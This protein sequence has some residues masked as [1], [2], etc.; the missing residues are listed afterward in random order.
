MPS[1]RPTTTAQEAQ[2]PFFVGVDLGGTNI[3]VG[4]VDN[5]GRTL[6]HGSVPT[7]VDSGAVD[8]SQRMG[9][10]VRQ[11]IQQAGVKQAEVA[12][13]GL[14]YAPGRWMSPRGYCWEPGESS[15]RGGS[16]RSAIG[17]RFMPAC[18]FATPMMPRRPHLAKLGSERAADSR[19]WY[20]LRSAPESAADS[21]SKAML[22]R[23]RTQPRRRMW[24]HHRRLSRQ[25]PNVRLP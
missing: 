14:G 4:L 11:I 18:R 5:L 22:R 17:W 23:R 20:S 2:P 25:C 12:Y 16:F 1:A 3:K 8:V 13:V 6:A 15:R 10:A 19:A 21:S 7:L 9:E 24:P